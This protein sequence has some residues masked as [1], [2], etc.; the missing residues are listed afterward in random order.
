MLPTLTELKAH[1]RIEASQSAENVL[2]E[3]LLN[4][5]IDYASQYLGRPLPWTDENDAQVSVPAS[6]NAAI[7]LVTADLYENR[8][9]Q[10]VGTGIVENP[11]VERLL[12]FHRVGMGI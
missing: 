2:L 4:A 6:I 11:A 10:I 1:L 5:A 9:A 8:E 7:L 3:N 12:H